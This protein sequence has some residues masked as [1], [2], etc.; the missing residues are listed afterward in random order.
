MQTKFELH[1]ASPGYLVLTCRG[2]L[3][4][5]EREH[6]AATV[7]QSLVARTALRGLVLDLG[8]VDFVNSAGLGALFQ[9]AQRIR[10]RGGQLAFASVPPAIQRLLTTVGMSR[11]AVF[12]RDLT[13][14]LTLLAQ[15]EAPPTGSVPL[16]KS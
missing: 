7:E 10:S 13:E 16:P 9:V 15:T 5:E 6:L 3:S 12:G 14:A 8:A 4:W 1:E 11:L 2:G